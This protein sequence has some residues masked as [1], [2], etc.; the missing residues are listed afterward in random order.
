MRDDWKRWLFKS[1]GFGAG[2][3]AV[4]AAV[5][6]LGMWYSSRP[7]P[8]KPWNK[9]AIRASFVDFGG[10]LQDNALSVTFTYSIENTTDYDYQ[11]PTSQKIMA[12]QRNNVLNEI[13]Q[14]WKPIELF[15]PA[16]HKVQLKFGVPIGGATDSIKAKEDHKWLLKQL[17]SYL[18]DTAGFVVFDEINRYE[19]KLPSG[20]ENDIKE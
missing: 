3:G 11:L 15:V 2:L 5:A 12:L 8:P 14:D 7:K 10:S 16:H 13:G 17:L 19:I 1:M 18:K 9:S 4:L 6:G 20:W